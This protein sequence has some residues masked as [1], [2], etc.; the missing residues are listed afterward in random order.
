MILLV[1]G[2]LGMEIVKAPQVILICSQGCE[3]LLTALTDSSFSLPVAETENENLCG[4]AGGSGQEAVWPAGCFA[5]PLMAAPHGRLEVGS[6]QVLRRK[7][8]SVC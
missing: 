3:P 6:R 5:C 8:G 7:G 2:S 1:G 4:R